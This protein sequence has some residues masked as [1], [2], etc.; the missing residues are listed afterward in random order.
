[1]LPDYNGS[2]ALDGGDIVIM[3]NCGFHHARHIEPL[4]QNILNR[5]GIELIDQPPYSPHL[6]TYEYCFNQIKQFLQL[7]QLL[8]MN[9]TKVAIGE[10]ICHITAGNSAGCYR[11]CGYLLENL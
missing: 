5:C 11:K 1:M 10:A 9:E 2:A 6:N 3:D 7:H 8:A 4:L